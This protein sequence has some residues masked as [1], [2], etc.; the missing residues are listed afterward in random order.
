MFVILYNPF[1]IFFNIYF[2]KFYKKTYKKVEVTVYLK[3]YI[4]ITNEIM[5]KYSKV[6]K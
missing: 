2:K 3:D 4:P 6:R 5:E 1:L